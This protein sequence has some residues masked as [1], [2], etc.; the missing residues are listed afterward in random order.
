MRSTGEPFIH[1]ITHMEVK[2][3]MDTHTPMVIMIQALLMVLLRAG[4]RGMTTA[5][6]MATESTVSTPPL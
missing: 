3:H 4:M 5:T 1:M 6:G 2:Q